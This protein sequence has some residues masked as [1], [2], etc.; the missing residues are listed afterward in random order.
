MMQNPAAAQQHA[1]DQATMAAEQQADQPEATTYYI[2]VVFHLLHNNG[3]ENISDEQILDAFEILNRDYDLGNTDAANVVNAFNASNPQA[4]A[5]PTDADIEFVLATKAPNGTCFSGITHTVSP[6]TV[7]LGD[8]ANGND[9]DN[10][11]G[12]DQVTAIRNGNDVFNGEWPGDEYLNIFICASVNGAAGYTYKP[13]NWI[14]D[15]M[16]NG[17]WVL[18]NYVGSIGTSSSGT[19]RTLTHE[20]GHWL[21]LDHPWGGTNNPGLASNCNTDDAVSDTPDCMG[22]TSCNLN[23]NS[24]SGD[25]AYWGFDQIDNTE[26]YM[27]YSYCSKMFTPGQVTR[28]RN[29]LNSSVGGRNNLKTSGNLASTG[30]DGNT[31]LCKANFK[32]SKVS[33]CAGE[34]VDFTDLS[35]NEVSGWTWTFAGG[36]PATSTSQNPSIT[37]NTPGLYEVILAATDGSSNDSETKSF[38]IRVS[39]DSESVP[40]LETFESFT[41]LEDIEEWEVIDYGD[42]AEFE[43]TTSVGHSGSNSAKL[44]NYAESAGN[45]DELVSATVDLSSITSQNAMT[46]T[47][48]YAYAKR[49]AA[50]DEWLKVYVSSNCG[51]TWAPRKTLHGD[52][53]GS[54]ISTSNWTP[55]ISDWVTVHMTNV[56][57]S[58]WTSDFKYK[59]EFESDGGNNFYLDDINIYPGSPSNDLVVGVEEQAELGH[60]TLFPNPAEAE[61]NVRFD[62]SNAQEVEFFI[63]DISGKVVK[64]SYIQGASGANL[65]V[66]GTE[67]L[68]SGMYF[69]KINAGGMQQSIQFVVK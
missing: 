14:G 13:S 27:D 4:T 65:V 1:Q 68:S 40:Y 55:S 54:T 53:L 32:A 37:Y 51:D 8:D 30:A 26:N 62:L 38:Y 49:S 18:H 64:A 31:Y 21:N 9:Q 48:R 36:T 44:P 42:N 43:L 52:L 67:E 23:A 5:I 60:L 19:S 50:N 12:W 22:L 11:D 59:F 25:N 34:T 66:I 10:V 35:Y 29:A 39:P 33:I 47:F 28:M 56:T 61:V 63:Q 24:C 2:P 7:N 46:L 15:G 6:L 69:L 41:T 45:F 57:S 20:V 16:D 58:Y 17:I 3:N